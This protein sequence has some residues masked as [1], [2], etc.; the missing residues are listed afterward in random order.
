M[1]GLEKIYNTIFKNNEGKE[2]TKRA[3]IPQPKPTNTSNSI[4]VGG[5]DLFQS[6]ITEAQTLPLQMTTFPA[7]NYTEM[8]PNGTHIGI[9]KK[10]DT[11]AITRGIEG[12]QRKIMNDT[13]FQPM[14]QQM[15]GMM[16]K[17]PFQHPIWVKKEKE[18]TKQEDNNIILRPPQLFPINSE[19][20]KNPTNI[21]EASAKERDREPRIID[22]AEMDNPNPPRNW[23]IKD[24]EI[25]RPLG[26][27]KFG[28]VYLARERESKYVVALKVMYKKEL[29][30]SHIEH[31][32]RREIEIQ[33]HLRHPNV[34]RLF[35]FFWDAKKIYLI[36]E[37]AP[38]G[39]LFKELQKQVI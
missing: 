4:Q 18:N 14:P 8:E 31:Q 25:G 27:G 3:P 6:H 11:P 9:N 10:L 15:G 26:R 12:I 7:Q 38:G 23:S 21:K 22:V 39:E 20:D 36:L 37:Y 13:P 28:H 32:L 29:M 17:A 30:A 5:Q 35:G 19:S 33:S 34:L 1:H 24:F 16:S 2:E